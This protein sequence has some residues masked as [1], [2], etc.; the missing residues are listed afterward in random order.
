[1]LIRLAWTAA[2]LAGTLPLLGTDLAPSTTRYRIDQSLSQE[3]DA[4]SAGGARENT[5]FNVSSF[6]TVTLKDSAGGRA[7]RVVV[8]SMRADSAIP[9][10]IAVLDSAKGATFGGFIARSGK[11]SELRLVSGNPAATQV[12]GLLSDFFPWIKS[13]ARVGDS[14]TDT[15]SKVNGLGPDSVTIRRVSAYKAAGNEMRYSR[16]AVRIAY[17]FTSSIAGTQPTPSGPARIE[18]TSTGQ[19]TYYVG[20]DG[21]YLGGDWQLQSSLRMSGAFATEPLP[22]TVVQKTR[23]TPLK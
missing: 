16:T 11:P 8:D 4:S 13:N 6:I 23:V 14:W 20:K 22:V 3:I 2:L 15:T 7:M 12:Q 1:M 21:R 19:G 18:G 17:D 5:S 10:P 9:F